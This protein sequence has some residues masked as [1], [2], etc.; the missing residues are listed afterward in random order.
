MED[1][2]VLLDTC[3]NILGRAFC[4][5]GDGATSP[6]TSGVQYFRAE[7]EEHITA[8]ACPLDPAAS[9]LFPYPPRDA[10]R[11]AGR[12]AGTVR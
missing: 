10:G 5:L 12:M 4:A 6:V 3:E 9:A 2:D 8:G 11:L 1:L 7:F